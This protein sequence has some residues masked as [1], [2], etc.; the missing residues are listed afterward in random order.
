[1]DE[2]RFNVFSNHKSLWNLF[3]TKK[4]IKNE[5]TK[6]LEFIKD[7]NYNLSHHLGKANVVVDALSRKHSYIGSSLV[8]EITLKSMKL[9]L[10][11]IGR[12]ITC[13]KRIDVNIRTDEVMR[14]HDKIHVLYVTGLRKLILQNR[15]SIGLNVWLGATRMC[16]NLRK[17]TVWY[18]L[19][20]EIIGI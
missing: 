3:I 7:Y 14:F 6:W 16:Q 20:E 13:D 8:C 11:K 18:G 2:S 1:M 12:V 4:G 5:T 17:M 15:F 19:E 9:G 10:L